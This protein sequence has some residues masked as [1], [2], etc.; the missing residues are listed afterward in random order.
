MSQ[1]I[2][3]IN[4]TKYQTVFHRD[5]S[6]LDSKTD[7]WGLYDKHVFVQ[8]SDDQQE[9]TY[10]ENGTNLMASVSKSY[11]MAIIERK[12]QKLSLK[13]F[14]G[15]RYRGRGN[16]WFKVS[17]NVEFLTLN[18]EKG[19]IYFGYLHDYQK[20]RKFKRHVRRNFFATDPINSIRMMIRNLIPLD[21][22]Q[23]NSISENFIRTFL[24][25]MDG[26]ED[27]KLPHTRRLFEFYLKGKGIKY[28]NNYFIYFQ[29][30]GDLPK[31]KT[32]RKFDMKLV[33]AFMHDNKLYGDVIKKVLHEVKHLEVN[34]VQSALNTFSPSM[35]LQDKELV[36]ELFECGQG[37]GIS[38]NTNGM[39]KKEIRNLLSS[40]RSCIVDKEID[41]WSWR[42][43][44][45]MYTY[46]KSVGENIKWTA[47]NNETFRE[48]HLDW[49]DK[50][51]FYRRGY[52]T[53]IY[54]ISMDLAFKIPIIDGDDV[55]YPIILKESDEYNEESKIQQ[56]CVKTY[57]GRPSSVIISLRK[58]STVSEERATIEYQIF[59]KDD[60]VTF[61][62][63]QSLG[64]Y[65]SRLDP[66][67]N[68]ALKSLDQMM[69]N[70]I[71]DGKNFE[72]IKLEKILEN[73][74]KLFSDSEWSE[75]GFL[76]W[77]YNVINKVSPNYNFFH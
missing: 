43:H 35:I 29:K 50:C 75:N 62:R 17:R 66:S 69:E 3:K 22:E 63:P 47:H 31:L 6:P 49:T 41:L 4:F 15:T 72:T 13:V 34:L 54:P 36:K 24:K 14:H 60:V 37:G 52:Y 32:L 19:D 73:R 28:P 64:K 56:N 48:E 77:T 42:D 38:F 5:H 67:W 9:I 21:N 65:N 20:K 57:I 58:N 76:F 61:N 40:F 30:M 27:S 33:D 51:D 46:L 39:S 26:Q 59:K 1:E 18:L 25:E 44:T 45:E 71:G 68:D 8:T 7:E 74:Q 2:L 11:M 23:S 55:L 53:R 10:N 12:E 70:W 16:A